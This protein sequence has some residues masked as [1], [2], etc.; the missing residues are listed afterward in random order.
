MALTLD[1]GAMRYP[2]A[3]IAAFLLSLYFTPLIRRGAIAYNVVDVPDSNLKQHKQATPYLGG[4]AIYLSFLFSLAFTYEFTKPVLGLLLSASIVVMLGLFDDLK[5]LTPTVKLAG[6]LV[7]ALVLVK[8][9]ISIRL[10]FLPQWIALILTVIWLVGL[11][12]AINLIDVSDG[13]AAGVSSVAG[14]FLYIVMLWNG[15][16][17]FGMVTLA[18][19]GAA[20]GFLAYNRAPA[21][22]FLGDAGSMFLGFMLGALA[23]NGHYT[24]K[25]VAAA[26]AP[27]VILGVPIFDTIFVMGARILRGIPVMRGSPDHFAV[28]LRN[29]GYRPSVIA[30]IGYVASG[31]LGAAA[32]TMC[33][34]SEVAALAVGAIIAFFGILAAFAL[35]R[36]GRSPDDRPGARAAIERSHD[37]DVAPRS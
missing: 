12:N 3:F 17:T 10:T 2:T 9:G 8:A 1:L 15:D 4:I 31:L 19:V 30:L 5:V 18:L 22:I 34:V 16:T 35:W 32:L 25:H 28:R 37:A 27:I 14:I 23:M 36:L 29:H 20:L 11:T 26:G 33:V 7:A 21:S 24:F 13:L 6:Q